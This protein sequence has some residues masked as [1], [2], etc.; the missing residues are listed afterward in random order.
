[1][2][3]GNPK[4]TKH[5]EKDLSAIGQKCWDNSA[6]SNRGNIPRPEGWDKNST[7]A[8]GSVK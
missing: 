3:N 2:K 7:T 6:E 4:P 8:R 1:M 5:P